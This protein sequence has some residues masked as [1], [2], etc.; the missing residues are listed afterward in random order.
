MRLEQHCRHYSYIRKSFDGPRI[1]LY[2]EYPVSLA[3]GD[4]RLDLFPSILL[5]HVSK[6]D[7]KLALFILLTRL[8]RM[9]LQNFQASLANTRIDLRA[10]TYSCLLRNSRG[11]LR[12]STQG[13]SYNIHSKYQRQ[14][15]G[16]LT[17]LA[18]PQDHSLHSP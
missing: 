3:T 11:N 5:D 12:I 2:R 17:E 10:Y 7:Y 8:E 14:H 4:P 6:L 1:C 9:L 18:L 16:Q 15:E 13:W